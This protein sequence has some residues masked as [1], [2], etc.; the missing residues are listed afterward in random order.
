MFR[1]K[2][3]NVPL[4]CVFICDALIFHAQSQ[5]RKKAIYLLYTISKGKRC[6]ASR[7][8]TKASFDEGWSFL[9]SF[10][11]LQD[12]S[13]TTAGRKIFHFYQS[14]LMDW[15]TGG[16]QRRILMALKKKKKEV[17]Q[18]WQWCGY[19]ER[20]LQQQWKLLNTTWSRC[21]AGC[22]LGISII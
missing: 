21:S 6:F 19:A 7:T 11:F 5:G 15:R 9:S 2:T 8:Q 4:I 12:D 13:T 20:S 16:W 14:S 10:Q 22:R 17:T 1:N 18:L 3:Q